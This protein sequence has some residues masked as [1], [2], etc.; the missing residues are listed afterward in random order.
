[1]KIE[2]STGE[3]ITLTFAQCRILLRAIL[4]E[5]ACGSPL[6]LIYESGCSFPR[7]ETITAE[8]LVRKGL[9]KRVRKGEPRRSETGCYLTRPGTTYSISDYRVTD[10]GYWQGD[11]LRAYFREQRARAKAL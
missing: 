3:A 1:M 7:R 8:A 5:E 6:S 4:R 9:L 10:E 11:A 2:T